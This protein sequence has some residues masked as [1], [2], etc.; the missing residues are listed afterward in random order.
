MA[1]I[2]G[3][4]ATAWNRGACALGDRVDCFSMAWHSAHSRWARTRPR[5]ACPVSCAFAGIHNATAAPSMMFF[6]RI[7]PRL[8]H[9]QHQ[10]QITQDGLVLD[11]S[12]RNRAEGIENV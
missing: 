3:V 4:D 7:R 11:L 6:N 8:H 1:V 2:P 9:T 10:K 12:Q 5:L